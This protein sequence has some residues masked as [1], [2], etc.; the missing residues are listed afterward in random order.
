MIQRFATRSSWCRCIGAVALFAALAG[1]SGC[2][3]S[4][5]KEADMTS[6]PEALEESLSMVERAIAESGGTADAEVTLVSTKNS[7]GAPDGKSLAIEVYALVNE[8]VDQAILAEIEEQWTQEFGFMRQADGEQVA[9]FRKGE[10]TATVGNNAGS[11]G[12]SGRT[13]FTV[14]TEFFDPDAARSAVAS[15]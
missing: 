15:R 9:T 3:L 4:S 6:A 7:L 2:A 11:V 14:T 5:D 10:R 12:G 1:V 8:P 13:W